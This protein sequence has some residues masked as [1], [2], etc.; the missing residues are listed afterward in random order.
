MR[1]LFLSR[2]PI[3]Q[4]FGG[5]RWLYE[6]SRR[7]RSRHD[8]SILTGS[9]G[10]SMTDFRERLIADG[11][12]VAEI[13]ADEDGKRALAEAARRSDVI[14]IMD[15]PS[16]RG[17][18]RS[19]LSSLPESRSILGHHTPLAVGGPGVGPNALIRSYY[20][21]MKPRIILSYGDV[22][23]HHVLTISDLKAMEKLT[24]A[25]VFHIE[26]GI[27][28]SQY[29]PGQKAT[30]PTLLFLGRLDRHKG[31]DRFIRLVRGISRLNSDV[32]LI[33]AGDGPLSSRADALAARYDFITYRGFVNDDEKRSLLSS[34]HFTL[35]LSRWEAFPFVV[36]ESMA[37]GTPVFTFSIPG[38]T[39]IVE[40]EVSGIIASG[41][42]DM[43][44]RVSEWSGR[45][46][47]VEYGKM[48]SR[49]VAR[50]SGN[51]W[52]SIVPRIESMF[53]EVS[54]R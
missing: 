26:N 36:L 32:Q 12:E 40:D 15:S 37:S 41:P 48:C 33:A 10:E 16:G 52:A 39:E 17:Q 5:E 8:V 25:P 34:S 51:D 19:V 9:S 49:A 27:D 31:F 28:I 3:N 54:S 45:T 18:L 44:A 46:G 23:A 4:G 47:S 2:H 29:A 11:V 24:S 14:Y 22:S 13:S 42:E 21:Y 6:V 50:A 38:P 1:I 53:R 30:R 35:M 20:R 7:L 43:A